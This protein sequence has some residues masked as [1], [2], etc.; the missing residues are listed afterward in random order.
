MQLL[1]HSLLNYLDIKMIATRHWVS[2]T[3]SLTFQSKLMSVIAVSSSGSNG[4]MKKT[5]GQKSA[6]MLNPRT[7]KHHV[8]HHRLR[9]SD[10]PDPPS[11]APTNSSVPSDVTAIPHALPSPLL[12]TINLGG[13][14]IHPE[15]VLTRLGGSYREPGKQQA[16]QPESAEEIQ[17]VTAAAMVHELIQQQSQTLE[18]VVPWFLSNMPSSY[19]RQTPP[20]FRQDHI[21]AISA[22]QDA[23]MDCTLNTLCQLPCL[24]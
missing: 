4:D 14:G 9:F 3:S 24:L 12:S 18:K 6:V 15:G 10:R 21:R 11:T 23:Q 17:R 16:W 8:Q 2:R 13:F 20:T 7:L 22:V 1:Y 19:F 5:L